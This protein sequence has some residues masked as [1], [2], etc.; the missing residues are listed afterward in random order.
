MADIADVVAALA[1]LAT[2]S[3]YPNG[4][5]GPP[6]A[7]SM[8]TIEQGWPLP[9]DLD[10]LVVDFTASP[11]LA[12]AI[13]SV[14]PRPG[15]Y[16]N[17]SRY[18][19]RWQEQSRPAKTLTAAVAGNQV[20]LGGAIAAGC[21]IAL[22]VGFGSGHQAFV[23]RTLTGDTLASAAASLAALVNA[24]TPASAT[25][26]AVTIPAAFAITARIGVDGTA[27]AELRRQVQTVDLHI[28][29]PSPGL[30]DQLGAPLR[31]ALAQNEFTVMP[32]LTAAQLWVA[33]DHW[34]DDPEKAGLY[35]R[36]IMVEA[37]YAT[38]AVMSAA[39]IIVEEA[40]TEAGKTALGT[41]PQVTELY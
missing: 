16:R 14:Y 38:T 29:T 40:Q 4:T 41:A 17:T 31:V 19:A 36:L 6:A 9:G 26:A 33:G 5:S 39:E 8:V 7:G 10:A 20:T 24:M 12:R 32:D 34:L 18:P 22:I 28:W 21:N 37:E 11:S 15:S 3:L 13:V 23:Y 25:G 35:R 27:I 30:R 1:T 2:T